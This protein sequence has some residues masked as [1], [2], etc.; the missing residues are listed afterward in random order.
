[1]RVTWSIVSKKM[2]KKNIKQ[3]RNVFPFFAAWSRMFSKKRTFRIYWTPLRR[4]KRRKSQTICTFKNYGNPVRRTKRRISQKNRLSGIVE[5]LC[6]EQHVGN[7]KKND[8]Q[9]LWDSCVQHKTSEISTN[10]L[11]GILGLLW[12]EQNVGNLKQNDF[13]EF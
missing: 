11:S 4:T 2:K 6:A 9:E 10:V 7:L 5:L 13:Q 8:I 1:M 12:A 3:A